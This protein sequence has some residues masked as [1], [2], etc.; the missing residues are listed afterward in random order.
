MSRISMPFYYRF[1]DGML[2]VL[3]AQGERSMLRWPIQAG[4]GWGFFG[5]LCATHSPSIGGPDGHDLPVV[6]VNDDPIS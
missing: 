5:L 6:L 2:R 4:R 1:T 3:Q